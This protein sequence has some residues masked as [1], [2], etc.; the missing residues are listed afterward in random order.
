MIN[1]LPPQH[2]KDLSAASANTALVRYI[3]ITLVLF[4]LLAAMS[5][6]TYVMLTAEQDNQQR[7]REASSRQIAQNQAIEQRQK[8]FETNLLIAKTIIDQQTN[9]SDVLL[10]IAKLMQPG[11]VL[12]GITLDYESYGTPMDIQLTAKTES[13]AIMLRNAFQNSD[14]FSNVQFKSLSRDDSK[15]VEYPVSAT[16]QVTINKEGA[17]K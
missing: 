13:D 5:G 7:E 6:L 10:K 1:L 4:V 12:S 9:Y 14:L 8:E 17:D 2:K 11:T 15:G 3:W 16:M